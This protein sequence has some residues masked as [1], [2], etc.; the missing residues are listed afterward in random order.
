MS[1]DVFYTATLALD[2][3]RGR[4]WQGVVY[5]A[6]GRSWRVKRYANADGGELPR[7]AEVVYRSRIFRHPNPAYEAARSRTVHHNL[8]HLDPWWLDRPGT[9]IGDIPA[10]HNRYWCPEG[11]RL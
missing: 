6:R 8:Y 4:R 11:V 1:A 7:G 9:V 2:T 3:P 10:S 5:V